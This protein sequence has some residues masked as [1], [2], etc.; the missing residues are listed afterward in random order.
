VAQKEKGE[1]DKTGRVEFGV[2]KS[3]KKKRDEKKKKKQQ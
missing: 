1:T 3:K 2:S